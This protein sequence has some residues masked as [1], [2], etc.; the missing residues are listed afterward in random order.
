MRRQIPSM[1]FA[2]RFQIQVRDYRISRLLYYKSLENLIVFYEGRSLSIAEGE[3]QKLAKFP[4]L[5]GPEVLL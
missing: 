2:L 3:S 4:P 5:L 1:P